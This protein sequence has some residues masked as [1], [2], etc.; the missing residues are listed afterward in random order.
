MSL[1]APSPALSRPAHTADARVTFALPSKGAIAEPTLQFLA[2]CGLRVEKPNPRQ[3]V[4]VMGSIPHVDVLF[5]RV[6]D[7]LFKVRDGTAQLGVTGLDVVAEYGNEDVLVIHPDL[8]YGHCKLVVAV[9]E[10]WLDVESMLDLAEVAD[11]FRQ[12]KGRN[13][14]V[15]TTYPN[16][17]RE[18]LHRHGIHHFTIAHAEGAIE[19]APTIGYADFIVDLVQTGTTLRENHLKPLED[20]VIVE[21]QACLIGNRAYLAANPAVLDAARILCEHIDAALQGRQ[22]SQITVNIQGADA[23]GI[24]AAIAANPLTRGL[25]SPTIAPIYLREGETAEDGRAWFTA[26]IIVPNRALLAAVEYLRGLGAS[27]CS[28]IPVRYIFYEQSGTFAG[29]L[30]ALDRA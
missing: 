7:V 13:I 19:A 12:T 24:A 16:Q 4:G 3:Y 15:A 5:Q 20:G 1:S 14:R 30:R 10:S 8:R 27:Q 22:F 29:L 2:D 11:D 25:Q 9:P 26:T 6:I 17:A 21:S 28:V 18:F 23:P